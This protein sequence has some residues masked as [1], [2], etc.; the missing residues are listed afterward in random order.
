M[1]Q[2]ATAQEIERQIDGLSPV[3]MKRLLVQSLVEQQRKAQRIRAL[4]AVIET[5]K[6]NDLYGFPEDELILPSPPCDASMIGS[7]SS[8]SVGGLSVVSSLVSSNMD[9]PPTP[10]SMVAPQQARHGPTT[11]TQGIASPSWPW[12]PPLPSAPPSSVLSSSSSS[13]SLP[14]SPEVPAGPIQV[15]HADAA[16]RHHY[17]YHHPLQG[18]QQQQQQQQQDYFQGVLASPPSRTHSRSHNQGH[19]SSA[20]GTEKTAAPACV[21][22]AHSGRV[23]HR[24]PKKVVKGQTKLDL[25]AHG[26]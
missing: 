18:L 14:L 25:K 6:A 7:S 22:T 13:S 21:K 24:P 9:T 19:G 15:P 11:P 4:I 5:F 17:H 1:H 20:H 26:F 23:D 12:L 3:E 8:S 2:N 10:T 16:Y